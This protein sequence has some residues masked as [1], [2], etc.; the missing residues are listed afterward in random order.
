MA[1]GLTHASGAHIGKELEDLK[2]KKKYVFT[3]WKFDRNV[4]SIAVG[5]DII[6]TIGKPQDSGAL[7]MLKQNGKKFG[8]IYYGRSVTSSTMINAGKLEMKYASAKGATENLGIQADKMIARGKK[9]KRIINGQEVISGIFTKSS[10]LEKSVMGHLK[11]SDKVPPHVHDAIQD[12]FKSPAKVFEWHDSFEPSEIQEIGKYFGELA[13]GEIVLSGKNMQRHF[14]DFSAFRGKKIKEFVVP[15]DP[16]FSGVD[17]AFICDDG[18]IIPIS[19]KL[20]AGAKASVFTNLLP[21]ILKNKNKIK[22]KAVIMDLADAAAA[23]GVD[24]GMLD[25]KRGSKEI[26][27]EYGVRYILGMDKSEV[28]NPIEVFKSIKAGKHTP[29]AEAVLLKIKDHPDIADNV[30]KQLPKSITAAFSREL[31]R[32]LN[33]DKK[34]VE[35][36]VEVLA[37]KDFWQANLDLPKWKKGDVYFKLLRSGDAKVKFVGDKAAIGDIDAL[38]GMLNYSLN[39]S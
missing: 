25:K 4:M 6:K 2:T 21:K 35:L 7:F 14:S 5:Y 9:E 11:S 13:I 23:A 36:V 27:Y 12:W 17:S 20:G 33:D 26:L 22:E 31:A 8:I 30:K 28:K 10:E 19:S 1:R 39:Y 34:S 38:Q 32:R 3:G 37:G 18:E 29:E 15:D 24:A 16:S